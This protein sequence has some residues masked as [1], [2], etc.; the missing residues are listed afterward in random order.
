MENKFRLLGPDDE[1]RVLDAAAQA[2]QAR[3]I[4]TKNKA[5]ASLLNPPQP[6]TSTTSDLI[7]YMQRIYQL[8][9]SAFRAFKQGQFRLVKEDLYSRLSLENQ[10]EVELFVSGTSAKIGFRNLNSRKLPVNKYFMLGAIAIR[11]GEVTLASLPTG[12]TTAEEA[13]A[14][15]GYDKPLPDAVL[16]AELEILV[17]GETIQSK[18]PCNVFRAE[19]NTYLGYVRL[20]NP[21]MI[22]PDREIKPKL[23][24][25]T[26]FT[27]GTGKMGV[28]EVTLIGMINEP[29]T[30]V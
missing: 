1:R 5:L 8:P 24:M 29:V 23:Y 27:A 10:K 7:R 26:S 20:D 18:T 17:E 22:M 16:N 9:V 21:V 15:V 3:D 30:A 13:I 28:L 11:Y 4:Q 12:A 14:L 2:E 25:P 6:E 19:N